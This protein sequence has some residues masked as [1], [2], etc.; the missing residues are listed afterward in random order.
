[1]ERYKCI[2]VAN[3]GKKSI[4]Y[5]NEKRRSIRLGKDELERLHDKS[6]TDGKPSKLFVV[7]TRNKLDDDVLEPVY[8]SELR[9]LKIYGGCYYTHSWH[10]RN[11]NKQSKSDVMPAVQCTVGK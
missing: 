7:D 8:C 1:M 4:I 11:T 2:V 3:T 5:Q 10:G 6:I 9:Y